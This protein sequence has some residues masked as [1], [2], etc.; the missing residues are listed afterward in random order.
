M[1]AVEGEYNL[2]CF[3]SV[4]YFLGIKKKKR[5]SLTVTARLIRKMMISLYQDLLK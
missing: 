2:I 3:K 5:F 1:V 4:S